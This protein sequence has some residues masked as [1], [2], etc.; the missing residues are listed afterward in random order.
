MILVDIQS[1]LNYFSPKCI[2]LF[3]SLIEN[4]GDLANDDIADDLQ[5]PLNVISGTVNRFIVCVSKIQHYNVD[6]QYLQRSDVIC[7]QYGRIQL[8]G[9]LYDVERDLLAIAKLLV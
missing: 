1:H 8:E 3:R 6:S 7:E 5:R 2:L 4:P 9:L